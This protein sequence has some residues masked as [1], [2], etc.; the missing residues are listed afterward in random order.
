MPRPNYIIVTGTSAGGLKALS[1]YVANLDEEMNAA[2]FI[3][4]HLARTAISDFLI[5]KLQPL[6]KFKCSIATDGAIIERGH[7]YIAGPNTH[8]LV[9]EE[10][11]KLGYGPEES[12]WK[13][14]ID[15]LFRSA[16]ATWSNKV[17]GIIL[18]GLLD[19]GATGMQ[20]IK[21]CGGICIV[22][23]PNEAEYPDMPLAVMNA[24]EVDSC[25]PIA[26]IGPLLSKITA[27]P[28]KEI[29]PPPKEVA[30][31]AGIAAKAALGFQAVEQLGEKSKLSC[32]SCGGGLY[33]IPEG[34]S[35]RYRCHI[36]H[37]FTESGLALKQ[38]EILESTLWVALRMM[39]ERKTLL[40]KM[41]RDDERRGFKTSS[42]GYSRKVT[43]LEAHIEILKETLFSAIK[44]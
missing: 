25:L 4:M 20:A 40:Q 1:E 39:E 6:T 28:V 41:G 17:I 2:I 32:P 36:G 19:D 29:I 8:L 33:T 7:I 5:L 23:D 21:K 37:A 13:P 22:Q 3:V 26:E 43:D 14:S 27:E 44:Q 38:N 30:I 10:Q 12:R 24:L 16:A 18:T 35:Q 42:A 15:I 9:Q 31:E 34:N 11:V